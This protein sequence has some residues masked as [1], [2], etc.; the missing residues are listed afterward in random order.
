MVFKKHES[1]NIKFLYIF[2]VG[3]LFFEVTKNENYLLLYAL[4]RALK[5]Y[6]FYIYK[7][8]K[9]FLN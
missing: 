9:N 1:F 8:F 5:I 7:F 6:C 2:L 4:Y 3:N